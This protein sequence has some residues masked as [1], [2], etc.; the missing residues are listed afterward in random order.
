MKMGSVLMGIMSEIEK[1]RINNDFVY[2]M[3]YSS[4]HIAD[5][6]HYHRELAKSLLNYLHIEPDHPTDKVAQCMREIVGLDPKT[7]PA[8]NADHEKLD[9][10]VDAYNRHMWQVGCTA[11][12]AFTDTMGEEHLVARKC[13]LD[14]LLF[15]NLNL[16]PQFLAWLMK[17][18][19][20]VCETDVRVINRAGLCVFAMRDVNS[21]LQAFVNGV[22]RLETVVSHLRGMYPIRVGVYNPVDWSETD[23]VLPEFPMDFCLEDVD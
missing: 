23:E 18:D 20:G 13:A 2:M 16:R 12:L 10:T 6:D 22:K 4:E 17:N 15:M 21:S 3:L 9:P 11:I 5:R 8:F 7:P 1:Q 14:A 19:S